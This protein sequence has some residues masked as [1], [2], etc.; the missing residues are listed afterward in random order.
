MKLPSRLREASRRLFP[1]WRQSDSETLG[2]FGFGAAHNATAYVT[3]FVNRQQRQYVKLWTSIVRSRNARS[4]TETTLAFFTHFTAGS[5]LVSSNNR[6]RSLMPPIRIHAGSMSAPWIR[7]PNRLYAIHQACAAH[8]ASG[9]TRIEIPIG[10]AAEF[11]R[12][13][14][15]K[16]TA[17]FAECGYYFLDEAKGVYRPTWKGAIL[18]SGKLR[19]PIKQIRVMLARRKA[20]RILREVG[21][22]EHCIAR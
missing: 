18:M 20:E 4:V 12:N 1:K 5:T 13:S 2:I 19:W 11:L 8:F 22:E 10:D 6:T 3:L 21:M 7:H 17:K 15:L 9:E 14:Q 16:E